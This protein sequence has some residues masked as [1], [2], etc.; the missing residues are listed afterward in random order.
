MIS[1]RLPEELEIELNKISKLENISK[2][3]LIK[4]ALYK[5]LKERDVKTCPYDLGKDLF[6]NY[7]SGSSDLSK[8][9]KAILKDRLN[10]KH[11]H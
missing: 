3:T 7:G 1:L 8:N 9:Y 4:N 2:S 11:S 10:E 5:Y 6:G